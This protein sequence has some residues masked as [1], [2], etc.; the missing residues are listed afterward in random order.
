M[1]CICGG[2]LLSREIR[3]CPICDKRTRILTQHSFGGY[4][5]TSF[6][7]SCGAAIQDGELLDNDREHSKKF[8]KENWKYGRSFKEV[9]DELM[10]DMQ[11]E[12]QK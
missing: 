4:V 5:T 3:I 10:K 11:E 2:G 6:C 1:S 12:E 8:V 9:L 7:G